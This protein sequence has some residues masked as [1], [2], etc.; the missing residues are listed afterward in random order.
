VSQLQ[1]CNESFDFVNINQDTVNK[2]LTSDET[3]FRMCTY[4]NK[5]SRSLP[6]SEQHTQTSPT[7]FLGAN[8]TVWLQSLLMA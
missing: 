3:H 4:V 7:T 5:H 1:L 8:V 6:Y 2:L